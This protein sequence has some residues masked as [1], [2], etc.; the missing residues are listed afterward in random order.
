[1]PNPVIKGSFTSPEAISHIACEKFV[2]GSPLYRQEQDWA[3]KGILLSR[4]TMSG[5]LIR[6]TKDWLFPLYDALK[7][8]LLAHEVL[9]SDETRVQV[10]QEPGKA[11]QNK[12]YTR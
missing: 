12:S 10:L 6:A 4:Q 9:H 1:M 8:K 11:P 3:R 2:M 5:W 7:T